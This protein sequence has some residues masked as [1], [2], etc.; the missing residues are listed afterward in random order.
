MFRIKWEDKFYNVSKEDLTLYPGY[1]LAPATNDTAGK[2]NDPANAETVIAGSNNQTVVMGSDLDPGSSE[3]PEDPNR[4]KLIQLETELQEINSDPKTMNSDENFMRKKT[5]RRQIKEL[6][7]FEQFQ[8][9]KLN[10]VVVKPKELDVNKKRRE[11]F[12]Q[13]TNDFLSNYN[14]KGKTWKE[15]SNDPNLGKEL[16]RTLKN[17]YFNQSGEGEVLPQTLIYKDSREGGPDKF[18]DDQFS[19]D[20]IYDKG[21]SKL[22]EK[23]KFEKGQQDIKEINF[24]KK[25]KSYGPLVNLARSSFE[26]A[27]SPNKKKVNE[28]GGK[29][30]KLKKIIEAGGDGD[31]VN[32]AILESQK[33]IPEYTQAWNSIQKRKE[34]E[35]TFYNPLTNELE[36]ERDA[37]QPGVEDVT[38][39]YVSVLNS[40][41]N[42]HIESLENELVL[43]E[44]DQQDFDLAQNQTVDISIDGAAGFQIGLLE[45]LGY[46]VEY[47]ENTTF[48]DK[49]DILVGKK[50]GR[51]VRNVKY[52]DLVKLRNS[53]SSD[54]GL[55]VGGLNKIFDKEFLEGIN[56]FDAK[57]KSINVGE[58]VQE[59]YDEKIDLQLRKNALEEIFILNNDPASKKITMF[60]TPLAFVGSATKNMGASLAGFFN[61]EESERYLQAL[62]ATKREKYDN[63]KE[64]LNDKNIP[65]SKDQQEN[66]KRGFAFELFGEALPGF[67]GDLVKFGVANKV[68]G[69][70]G[71]TARI[72]KLMKTEPVKAFFANNLMEGVKFSAVMADPDMFGEGF[73]FG[74]GSQIAGKLLPKL[75][76][77]LAKYNAAYNKIIGGGVGM[78]SGSEV[79]ALTHAFID[80]MM[81]DKAFQTSLNELYG[82]QSDAGRRITLNLGMGGALGGI[83]INPKAELSN[84][85]TRR[86]YAKEISDNIVEGKYKGNELAKKKN[87]FSTFK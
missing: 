6:G 63:Y 74:A 13:I 69:G 82:E 73:Y 86:N 15:L 41:K 48:V 84:M 54:A 65:L 30:L 1:E 12:E 21:V 56:G 25:T 22:L 32:K 29:L 59:L 33:I 51:I 36:G 52:S 75:K 2:T 40:Y 61:A 37:P 27:D 78:A 38:N 10:E 9:E 72:Q 70:L 71:I 28:L 8:E 18:T 35:K 20:A 45:E 4:N 42:K 64:F 43:R 44:L 80:N 39:K 49:L 57:G 5:L 68:A 62:P 34:G 83:K 11:K 67:T 46:E 31:A 60:G 24:L 17:I 79:A 7:G 19:I 3:L 23:E 87:A 85:A 66:F 47:V 81:G 55:A 16:K 14:T 26:Y 53:R 77:S 58:K 76:G 50:A